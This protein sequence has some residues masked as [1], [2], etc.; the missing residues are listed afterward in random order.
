MTIEIFIPYQ[1][2]YFLV[3]VIIGNKLREHSTSCLFDFLS[4]FKPNLREYNM[5]TT[6]LWWSKISKKK[7]SSPGHTS[8]PS[9]GLPKTW[10]Q[11]VSTVTPGSCNQIKPRNSRMTFRGH[12]CPNPPAQWGLLVTQYGPH[13]QHVRME[14][15]SNTLHKD[16]LTAPASTAKRKH[17][18]VIRTW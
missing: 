18:L 13:S 4:G 12:L 1:E 9:I 10:S 14:I 5:N 15:W 7:P 2:L 8:G 6:E 3:K 11:R 17:K 16:I